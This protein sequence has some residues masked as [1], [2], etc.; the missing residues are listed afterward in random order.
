MQ[1][2]DNRRNFVFHSAFC[3][4]N[5]AFDSMP[6]LEKGKFAGGGN[7]VEIDSAYKGFEALADGFDNLIHVFIASFQNQFDPAIG[8]I[9]DVTP[10]IILLSDVL[11]RVPKSHSLD[12]S[13]EMTCFSV[14]F[15]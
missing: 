7:L 11:S 1:N 9:L 12:P 14:H 13:A 6:D 3:L 10:D 2:E 15:G 5:S 4:L 8:Q